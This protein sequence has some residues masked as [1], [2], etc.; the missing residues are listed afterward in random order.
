MWW[1]DLLYLLADRL[2]EAPLSLDSDCVASKEQPHL[3]LLRR[4]H[5]LVDNRL[6]QSLATPKMSA[7]TIVVECH[8]NVAMWTHRKIVRIVWIH[9]NLLDKE[10]HT[11][12]TNSEQATG[13]E[14]LAHCEKSSQLSI[15][16]N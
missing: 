5:L 10:L 14:K 2:I 1:K 16:Y 4:N 6:I 8:T 9:E 13:S 11:L 7:A 12:F 15:H 3:L